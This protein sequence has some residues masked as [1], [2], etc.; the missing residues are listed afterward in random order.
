MANMFL[1]LFP[2]PEGRSGL[3]EP[4]EPLAYLFMGQ[5]FAALQG[6]FASLHGFDEA[7]LFFEI[8]RYDFPHHVIQVDALLSCPL[9][10]ACL[11]VGWELHFHTQ[12]I[13]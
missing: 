6:R 4:P 12:T 13:R 1:G 3:Q 11:Y 2:P 10:Q 9:T 7:I 5:E 8:A